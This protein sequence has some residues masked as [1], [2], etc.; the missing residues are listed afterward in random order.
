MDLSLLV[1]L[2]QRIPGNVGGRLSQA[3]M[4]NLN[5]DTLHSALRTLWVQVEGL[6]AKQRLKVS[7]RVLNWRIF[8]V[9]GCGFQ[10]ESPLGG[11]RDLVS[12]VISSLI[13]VISTY[14]F[15][16]TVVNFLAESHDPPSKPSPPNPEAWA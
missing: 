6:G 11:S 7:C 16:F 14:N 4:S 13:G 2:P 10:G 8:R 15:G 5:T 1:T 3:I 9:E 12:K